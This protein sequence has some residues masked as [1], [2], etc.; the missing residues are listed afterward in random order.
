VCAGRRGAAEDDDGCDTEGD[1]AAGGETL[2]HGIPSGV[3]L[4]LL[5]YKM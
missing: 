5:F 4:H 2:L 3:V 1:G